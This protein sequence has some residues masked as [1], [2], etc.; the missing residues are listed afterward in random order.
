M[1]GLGFT[2][3]E[4][5]NR[6]HSYMIGRLPAICAALFVGAVCLPSKMALAN[7][8]S[9]GSFESGL[10]PGVQYNGVQYDA[11]SSAEYSYVSQMTCCVTASPETLANWT[12]QGNAGV[13]AGGVAT[14]FNSNGVI[15]GYDGSQYAFL[16]NSIYYTYV[17]PDGEVPTQITSSISQ[18]FTLA[19]DANVSISWLVSGRQ[20][21]GSMS[22]TVT[23]GSLT[24]TDSVTGGSAFTSD[25]LSG[26]LS[27]GTYT[28]TFTNTT[29]SSD[30]TVYLDDIVVT[31]SDISAP[32]P[33]SFTLL[34]TGLL[35]IPL[36]R[37]RGSAAA[38]G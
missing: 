38:R 12:W 26:E 8:I 34:A 5:N 29:D 9:N 1:S 30:A 16:Q 13:I 37:R 36:R 24:A 25:S 23:A 20:N 31:E 14:S 15:S 4:T 17:P 18:S 3:R 7:L 19:S 10:T 28:L 22:Y 35:W 33:A 6:G 11:S 21:N 2:L 27:A 32:E